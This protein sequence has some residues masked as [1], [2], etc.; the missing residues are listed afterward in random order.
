VV[1][2]R[3]A[4]T[5]TVLPQVLAQLERLREAFDRAPLLLVPYLTPGVTRRLVDAGVEF[6]DGAGNVYL[7]GN[8]AYVLV[9][10]QKRQHEPSHTGLTAVALQLVYAFLVQHELLKATYRELSH[11]TGVSLGKIS[12]TV[13]QLEDAGLMARGRS[14][15]LLV[16]DARELLERWEVGYL[17]R[18]RPRLS[19]TRWQLGKGNQLEDAAT[20]SR[21][22]DGVLIGGEFAAD[23]FFGHLRPGTLTLHVPEGQSREVAVGLRLR[24]AN[25]TADVVLLSR[26]ATLLDAADSTDLPKLERSSPTPYAHPVLVRAELLALD[27]SR[28]R[29]V[30]DRLLED[31]ILPGLNRG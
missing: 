24:P 15:A 12:T 17:E 14:G 20:A 28:L 27:D 30:A 23:A 10:D 4:V 18:L 21:K 6:A 5:T 3:S 26:F 16:R 9:L 1:E 22:L 29:Q 25:G 11:K 8:A 13:R 7:D 2:A 31:L 19:P